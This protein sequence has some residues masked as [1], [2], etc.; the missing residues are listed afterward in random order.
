VKRMTE[1][2]NRPAKAHCGQRVL[3][4]AARRFMHMHVTA[5]DGTQA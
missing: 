2:G 5:R 4:H 3:Q 1:F